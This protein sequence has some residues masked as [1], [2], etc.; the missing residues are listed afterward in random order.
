MA[1]ETSAWDFSDAWIM[2]AVAINGEQGC[3]LAELIGA[4]DA[5]NHALLT[6]EELS[7][8][9]GR[10]VASGLL[11]HDGGRFHLTDA[12]R[13]LASRRKGGMIGQ[14][15]S[16]EKL[17]ARQ[18][19]TEGRWNVAPEVVSAAVRTYTRTMRSR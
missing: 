12:G 3:D 7:R 11:S 10:L 15:T 17:L 1:S 14:V 6:D 4:A 8:G 13:A 18:P 9:V 19:V 2:T 16:M 5:C